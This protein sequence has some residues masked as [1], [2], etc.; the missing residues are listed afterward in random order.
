MADM[1]WLTARKM[2]RWEHKVS[3][4]YGAVQRQIIAA[5]E[6]QPEKR[7]TIDTLAEWAYPNIP[8]GPSQRESVRRALG[9][10]EGSLSLRKCRSGVVRSG[11]WHHTFGA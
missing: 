4:G 9:K 1:V 11:G 5:F 7:W 6:Q 3:R 8:I 10:L 2:R